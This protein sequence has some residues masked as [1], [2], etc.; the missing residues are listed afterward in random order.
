M[1]SSQRLWPA[2]RSVSV[3]DSVMGGSLLVRDDV[4]SRDESVK[5]AA[6]AARSIQAQSRASVHIQWPAAL[7]QTL[8]VTTRA[9]DLGL[10]R[11]DDVIHGEAELLGE[12]FQRRRGAEG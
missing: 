6:V 11:G 10:G 5:V 9:S 12:R 3:G 7:W 8:T 2:S 1:L 4:P